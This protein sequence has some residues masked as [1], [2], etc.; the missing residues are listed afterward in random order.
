MPTAKTILHPEKW[1]RNETAAETKAEATS[2]FVADASL[3]AHPEPSHSPG[4][5]SWV[6]SR[7]LR[8]GLVSGACRDGGPL[9]RG[10][11]NTAANDGA[12]QRPLE[13]RRQRHQDPGGQSLHR[14]KEAG[15][16]RPLCHSCATVFGGHA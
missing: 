7:I 14:E 16:P 8:A 9:H 11:P 1:T 15:L 12:S 13:T 4:P 10:N 3:A 5:H 2:A 6:P